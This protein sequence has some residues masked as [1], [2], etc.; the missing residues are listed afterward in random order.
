M[1]L[2]HCVFILFF[3]FFRV[4]TTYS[5]ESIL[6]GYTLIDSLVDKDYKELI[7]HFNRIAP[8]YQIEPDSIFAHE[9]AMTYLWKAHQKND[10]LNMGK[11]YSM[12]GQ[13]EDLRLD[14]L[15]KAI[16]YTENY[17]DKTQPALAYSLKFANYYYQGENQKASN[18]LLEAI[19]YAR[20]RNNLK[21]LK[22]LEYN[23]NVLNSQWGDRQRTLKYF[24]KYNSFIKSGVYDSLFLE[25]PRES[26]EQEYID[27]QYSIAKNYYDAKELKLASTYI[28]SVYHYG[29]KNNIDEYKLIF[30]GLKGG[31]LYR[32][33][34]YQ[35]ALKYTNQFLELEDPEDLYAISRSL[36]MKGLILWQLNR[37]EEAIQSIKKADSLYQITDDEFEELGEGYQVLIN[38][39]KDIGETE[40]QLVYL[41]KLIEFDRKISSNYIEIGNRIAQEYT[42]PQL[43]A[44]KDIV[45]SKLNSEKAFEKRTK[46][47]T[48]ILLG[49]SIMVIVYYIRTYYR[50]K[51]KFQLLQETF[52]QQ[53]LS[54]NRTEVQVQKEKSVLNLEEK[55]IELIS[56][57][58]TKFEQSQEFLDG[59]VTLKSL[60]ERLETNSSYLSKYINGVKETNFSTYISDLRIQ[61]AI[62]KLQEDVK[63]RFYTVEAIA[64]EVGFSN[65]RSFTNHFKRVTGIT[66]SYFMK[67]L[68]PSS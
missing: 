27:V 12:L 44:E 16:A 53:R 35:E 33:G 60:A 26:K 10:S 21:M 18:M 29:L 66:V 47:I 55:Q 37:K 49:V 36:N 59:T 1:R 68:F 61:H 13:L 42:L 40:N 52:E 22:E 7:A 51:K 20:K 41:N 3:C 32:E 30:F 62:Y 6:E 23:I 63:F 48:F 2:Q 67:R 5:Q 50:S 65:T 45:I 46:Y 57:G 39:Y 4:I 15:D 54:A 58:L 11:A 17:D 9:V 25:F 34:A 14:Y 28:D 43:L 8:N 38:H 24:L 64:S 19:E 56:K 31:I